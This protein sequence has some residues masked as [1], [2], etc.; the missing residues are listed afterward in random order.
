ML[1]D[2]DTVLFKKIN[3]VA[4]VL[5][6]PTSDYM[7]VRLKDG[8]KAARFQLPLAD[9]MRHLRETKHLLP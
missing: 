1:L 2:D 4:Q 7:E 6:A 8:L 9:L 3:A 5:P